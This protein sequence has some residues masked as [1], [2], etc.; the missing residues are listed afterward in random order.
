MSYLDTRGERFN[1]TIDRIR[2]ELGGGGPLLYRYSGQRREEG[3]FVACS[4]WLVEAL[5]RAGRLGEARETM[6]EL[7]GYANDVRLFA[8]EID[9]RTR[10][11]LGNFPQGLSH[12]ALVNAAAAVAEE[13]NSP[14]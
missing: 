12:L 10:D 1:S 2:T 5:A 8:E 6:D 14:G 7:V 11:F 4:F 9:P 13:S 3:A